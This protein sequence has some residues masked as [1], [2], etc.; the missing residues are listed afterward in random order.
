MPKYL[1]LLLS[2]SISNNTFCQV[3]ESKEINI[4]KDVNLNASSSNLTITELNSGLLILANY[5]GLLSYDGN[6]WRLEFSNEIISSIDYD[7]IDNLL[8]YGAT[9]HFGYIS[10]SDEGFFKI[11]KLSEDLLNIPASY[12]TWR[13]YSNE[14]NKF[15]ATNKGVFQWNINTNEVEYLGHETRVYD[16]YNKLHF[17]IEDSLLYLIDGENKLLKSKILPNKERL[18]TIFQSDDNYSFIYQNGEIKGLNSF[19]DSINDKALYCFYLKDSSIVFT[20]TEYGLQLFDKDLKEE[21]T[22]NE[23]NGLVDNFTRD[24]EED[25]LGNLWVTSIQGVSQLKNGSSWSKYDLENKNENIQSLIFQKET[26]YIATTNRIFKVNRG[27]VSSI[28]IDFF[29]GMDVLNN[30]VI[31]GTR[32]GLVLINDDF[33]VVDRLALPLS[34][35]V[36]FVNNK[37]IVSQTNDTYLFEIIN[38]KLQQKNVLN[39]SNPVLPLSTS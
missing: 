1:F 26:L 21:V 13:I 4:F 3:L 23:T 34:S 35:F 29:L 25:Q 32:N 17:T 20:N 14:E 11:N 36:K 33:E 39:L 38:N 28:E 7:S 27:R 31:V 2:L 30:Q 24:I 18:V 15:F 5:E 37:L 10:L 16:Y 19:K 6:N 12:I 22:L 9:N 8:L